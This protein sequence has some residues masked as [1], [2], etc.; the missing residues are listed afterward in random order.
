VVIACSGGPDSTALALL[1][2]HARPDLR[3]ILA[4]VS[5]GLRGEED[6]AADAAHVAALAELLD[7][8]HVVLDVSV[9]RTG[10][11]IES[12]ARDV[13][14]AA[15]EAEADRRGAHFVL[16]GHHAEDQA[17]TLLLRLA[18]GTGVEGLAGMAVTTGRRLRPLL[19][20]RRDDLHRAADLLLAQRVEAAG[21][22]ALGGAALGPARHDPM[23]DDLA[24]ARVRLRRE[25][26]PALARLGPDPVGALA[27][28]AAIARDESELLDRLVDELRTTLPLVTFGPVA[29]IPSGPLRD[30]PVALARR[31]LR[32]ALRDAADAA[33]IERLLAAPDGWRATLP[34]PLDASVE[35]GWHVLAPA[36]S[37]AP[38]HPGDPVASV[39]LD[40]ASGGTYVHAASGVRIMVT[41]AGGGVVAFVAELPGGVPPGIDP[42]R[43]AVRVRSEGPLRLRTRRDGDRLRTP[44]GTRS[45]GD[46]LGEVGVPRALRD[47]LPV[48]SGD[49]PGEGARPLW[50]PGVV[51]DTTV[52]VAPDAHAPPSTA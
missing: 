12:D 22:A 39:L 20:V 30:L 9:V 48:I 47:L 4:Y 43:L 7:A 36:D 35:R 2:A 27:R 17:E 19:D 32:S 1:V 38:G 25:V 31:V 15:L 29:M 33:T 13:R 6:D 50:V 10:G 3:L 24:V 23:N 41:D 44:G 40:V 11:G 37:A 46:I 42:S 18:R 26:L 16:H 52:H 21:R 45:L 49:V 14:H 51:V 34:G 8:D 5:H 28:L